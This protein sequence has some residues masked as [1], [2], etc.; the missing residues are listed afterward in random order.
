LILKWNDHCFFHCNFSFCQVLDEADQQ[1]TIC[2]IYDEDG[3]D[4]DD[5]VDGDDNDNE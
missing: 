1:K 5:S 2:Y 4:G 3:D